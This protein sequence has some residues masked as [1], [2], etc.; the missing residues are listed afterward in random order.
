MTREEMRAFERHP[1]VVQCRR[2]RSTGAVI[3]VLDNRSNCWSG[4]GRWITH[5]H[6]HGYVCDHETREMAKSWASEPET[7]CEECGGRDESQD[8]DW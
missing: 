5:C 8:E 6:D 3:S 2:A 1:L 7:W 4:D